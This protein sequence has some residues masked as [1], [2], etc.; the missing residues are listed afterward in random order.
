MFVLGCKVVDGDVMFDTWMSG[1]CTVSRSSSR[2]NMSNMGMPS[3]AMY[4]CTWTLNAHGACSEA[5]ARGVEGSLEVSVGLW[6]LEN[7]DPSSLQQREQGCKRVQD[8]SHTVHCHST[9]HR[10]T[11]HSSF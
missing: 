7:R 4:H 1:E 2:W 6:S 11:A 8:S 3:P 5:R 10:L 9:A